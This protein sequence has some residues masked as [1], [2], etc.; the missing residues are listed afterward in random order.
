MKILISGGVKN[1]KSSYAE[2]LAIKIANNKKLYYLATMVPYDSEDHKRIKL[3]QES[4]KDKGFITIEVATDIDRILDDCDTS[5]TF[6]LDSLTA[7]VLNEMFENGNKQIEDIS[8]K[9][10]NDLNKLIN[11]VG[12][13]VIVTDYIFSDYQEFSDFTID[14]LKLF[15]DISIYVASLCDVVIERIVGNNNVLK[16]DG[17]I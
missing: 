17:L 2:D 8:S 6:L 14:Y 16:G 9:I 1:A 13:I 3:H 12:N 10:K 4:R 11:N 7:Y 15:A 5:S